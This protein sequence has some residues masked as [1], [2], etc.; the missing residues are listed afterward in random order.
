MG[1]LEFAKKALSTYPALDQHC[2]A[3]THLTHEVASLLK[4]DNCKEITLAAYLHD[5]GKSTWPKE[6]FYKYPL[7]PF[8]WSLITAHPLAGE[9]LIQDSWPEAPSIIK[10]IIRGHHERPGGQGY[11]DGLQEPG[12]EI[13]IVAACDTFDAITRNKDYQNGS[14]LSKEFAL[15]QVSRFAPAII[16]DALALSIKNLEQTKNQPDKISQQITLTLSN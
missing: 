13:L 4:I 14:A 2:L 6:L 3:V 8:D 16:V 9:N 5:I 12:F 7:Q 1:F 15:E 10:S 11:P